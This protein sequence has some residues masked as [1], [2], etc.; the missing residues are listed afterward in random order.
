MCSKLVSSSKPRRDGNLLLEVIVLANNSTTQALGITLPRIIDDHQ[1]SLGK[2]AVADRA[3]QGRQQTRSSASRTQ[4][5]LGAAHRLWSGFTKRFLLA[6]DLGSPSPGRRLKRAG[7][8][9]APPDLA[10]GPLS[11]NIY[12]TDIVTTSSDIT[13]ETGWSGLDKAYHEPVTGV[14]TD[15]PQLTT[16]PRLSGDNTAVDLAVEPKPNV[17][18]TGDGQ[19]IR[20]ESHVSK[21]SPSNALSGPPFSIENLPTTTPRNPPIASPSTLLT[22]EDPDQCVI[23]YPSVVVYYPPATSSNTDCLTDAVGMPSATLPPGLEP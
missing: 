1:S 22:S 12:K 18:L 7:D 6:E 2:P 15:P 10:S 9:F 21:I 11:S 8:D 13:A 5:I 19:D 16:V 20:L 23:L 4:D 3:L 14:P 17:L